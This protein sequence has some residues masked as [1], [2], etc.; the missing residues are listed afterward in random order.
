MKIW[1]KILA[2]FLTSYYL[3]LGISVWVNAAEINEASTSLRVVVLP[4]TNSTGQ[5][6][7][8]AL[9][10]G[11]ADLLITSLSQYPEIVLV[12]RDHLPQMLKEFENQLQGA[13]SNN[14]PINIGQTLGADRLITGGLTLI[15]SKLI[16]HAHVFDVETTQLLFS[17]KVVGTINTIDATREELAKKIVSEIKETHVSNGNVLIDPHP[18][19]TLHFIRGLGY[20]YGN[21][22]DH[23][24]AEF[25]QVLYFEPNYAEA[26]FWLGRSYYEDQAYDHA[27]VEFH[28]FV[29][30]FPEHSLI[31]EVRFFLLNIND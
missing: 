7:F 17:D 28:R 20:Y 18:E 30:G 3:C 9:S 16:V 13:L 27:D 6:Q 15:D 8:D 11:F 14:Q 10:E 2:V 24:I 22:F 1:F 26:R 19:V 5:K 23:A 21:L 29:K 12:E 25:M 4:F 31:S